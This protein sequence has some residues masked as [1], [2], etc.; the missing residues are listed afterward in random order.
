MSRNRAR[1][2]TVVHPKKRSNADERDKKAMYLAKD[3]RK[4]VAS[5]ETKHAG[6]KTF[7]RLIGEQVSLE[8]ECSPGCR[9][10]WSL[11]GK[12]ALEILIT[13]KDLAFVCAP[14]V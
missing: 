3:V 12:R 14:S 10:Y 13:G 8:T 11:I 5:M 9:D 4:Q 2:N 1:N 6:P 7:R